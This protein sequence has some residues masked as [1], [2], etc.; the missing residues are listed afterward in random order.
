MIPFF[1]NILHS[2][3]LKFT[4]LSLEV[5]LS[6]FVVI[7]VLFCLFALLLVFLLFVFFFFYFGLSKITG[8]FTCIANKKIFC[9]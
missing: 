5:Y 2:N 3:K 6:V 7:V 8:F 1:G 9:S 4:L